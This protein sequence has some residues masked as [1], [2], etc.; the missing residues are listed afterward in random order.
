MPRTETDQLSDHG[1]IRRRVIGVLGIGALTASG[2]GL[3]RVMFG[4]G[5][6][7]IPP[8]AAVSSSVEELPPIVSRSDAAAEI[9]T[10]DRPDSTSTDEL[11]P[12]TLQTTTT[13]DEPFVLEVVSRSGWDAAS[14]GPGLVEHNPVHLTLHHTAVEQTDLSVG[15][16]RMR[17]HQTYH[18]SLGWPDLAYHFIVDRAGVAY[19]GRAIQFRGDTGTDYDPDGHF[20]VC[21]EGNFDVQ[22]PSAAQVETT[23]RLFAWAAAE[24]AIDPET[25]AGH[26][27]YAATSCP[28][29]T[30]EV[31]LTEL[32]DRIRAATPVRV[33]ITSG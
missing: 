12:E 7:E 5:V 22:Q 18:Q 29:Q 20:L 24:Y 8:T 26:S 9:G 27:A 13:I 3:W 16:A 19:E 32:A 11:T 6:R 2:V 21:M 25:I 17:Q 30:T 28:G 15:P 10:V 4:D 14:P 31:L 23:T 33:S 1:N